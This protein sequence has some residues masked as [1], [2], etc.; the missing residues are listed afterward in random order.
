MTISSGPSQTLPVLHASDLKVTVGANTGDSIGVLEDL[1]LDD[2]YELNPAAE[3][4]HLTLATGGEH[5]FRVDARSELGTPD[6]EVHLDCVLSL[7]SPDGQTTDVLVLVEVDHDGLIAAIY[8]LPLAPLLPKVEYTLLRAVRETAAQKLAQVACV[9]FTRG[10]HITLATGAQKKIEELQVG[11]RILTRDDG[12]QPIRWIGQSTVRATGAM[13]PIL[14]REAALNNAHDLI[15]SPDHRLFIY[16]R[17]DALGTGCPEVLVK[18]RHLVNGET[19]LQQQGGFVDYFQILFDRHHIIYA[20]GIA[21]E[22]MY[23]DH[24]TR[25]ALPRDLLDKMAAGIGRHG[26]RDQHGLDVDR[27]S[28]NPK[29]AVGIL[30]GASLG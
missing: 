30:R 29:D 10:T 28:L 20:E 15:V 2:I 3:A 11:D 14:I 24:A 25:P 7:M 16:Q 6:H 5:G 9:S 1:D 13:A 26:R 21:A 18:A 4:A 23:L 19:V 8:A 22:S 27:S 17:N 12:I